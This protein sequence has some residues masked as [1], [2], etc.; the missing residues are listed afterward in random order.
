MKKK[1]LLSIFT[2]FMLIMFTGCGNKT[3][4]VNDK[5]DDVVLPSDDNKSD[6]VNTNDNTT[7]N[8]ADD[9]ELYSDDTKIVF[10]NGQVSMVFY[11]S[12]NEITAFHEYI[13]Y[14]DATTANYALSIIEQDESISKVYTKG[15]YLVIEYAESEYADYTLEDIKLTYSYLE[16]AKKQ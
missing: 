14:E 13:E 2:L 12:G 16:E 6:E 4:E 10:K 7:T 3:D 11:Y 1:I 5:P 15:R 9:Y 8:E